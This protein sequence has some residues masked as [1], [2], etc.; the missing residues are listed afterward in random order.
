MDELA[1]HLDEMAQ[2]E[3]QLGATLRA[4]SRRVLDREHEIERTLQE[5]KARLDAAPQGHAPEAIPE[6]TP[7]ATPAHS[8]GGDRFS[9]YQQLVHQVREIVAGATPPGSKVLLVSKGDSAL[10]DLESR[11]GWHFPQNDVGTYAGYYPADG[12]LA[13]TDLE[14]L[15]RKGAT[16]L[17]LPNPAF[18]WLEYYGELHQHLD[19]HYQRTWAD[20]RCIIYDLRSDLQARPQLPA[21]GTG[22]VRLRP[23]SLPLT[24]RLSSALRDAAHYG[25]RRR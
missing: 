15:R 4:A 3:A 10:V 21:Q 7:E 13:V 20:G 9:E 12:A 11:Y 24:R 2:R 8:A 14:A 17:V 18:W 6:A 22:A 23:Q 5:L 19:N 1:L 16:F 25:S